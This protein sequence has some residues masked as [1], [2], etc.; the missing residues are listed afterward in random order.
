MHVLTSIS[1]YRSIFYGFMLLLMG[2]ITYQLRE[3]ETLS[4]ASILENLPSFLHTCAFS[5]ITYSFAKHLSIGPFLCCSFW[6]IVNVAFE[7]L[8]KA[9]LLLGVFDFTDIVYSIIGG[10]LAYFIIKIYKL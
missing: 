3:I 2:F 6:V 4:S 7:L 5:F 10:L 9:S 8:Q 1:K